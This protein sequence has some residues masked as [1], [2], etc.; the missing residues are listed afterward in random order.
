MHSTLYKNSSHKTN[1]R[2]LNSFDVFDEA[3]GQLLSSRV[4]ILYCSQNWCHRKLSGSRLVTNYI[5]HIL[6]SHCFGNMETK[7]S[8]L[9]IEKTYLK[10]N[11]VW[12]TVHMNC[13]LYRFF[14]SLHPFCINIVLILFTRDNMSIKWLGLIIDA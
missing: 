4:P 3:G 10:A 1:G 6:K 12:R 8:S 11:Y 7:S 9:E 2:V 13:R 5:I 14:I